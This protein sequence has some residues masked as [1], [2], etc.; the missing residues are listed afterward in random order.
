[1]GSRVGERL[2]AAG[3]ELVAWNRTAAKAAAL[4]DHGARI[5]ASPAQ[6]AERAELV[7]TMLRDADA[8][9]A[10][11][12]GPD[13]LAAGVRGRCRTVVE[14]STVGPAAIRWLSGAL[15]AG[16]GLVDAPVLGSVAEAASGQL[17]ILAGG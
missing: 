3:H 15:P 9:R 6:V 11:T 14:M 16:I 1:M 2:L 17:V 5:L 12:E 4:A 10:V 7:I 13:G 8:L